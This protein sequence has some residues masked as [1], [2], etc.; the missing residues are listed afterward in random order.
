MTAESG[1]LAQGRAVGDERAHRGTGSSKPLP[2]S[3]ESTNFW[4]L[5]ITAGPGSQGRQPRAHQRAAD[6]RDERR[7]HRS[8]LNETC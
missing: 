3:G 4:F 1:G 7:A 5:L 6:R 8:R 2:S